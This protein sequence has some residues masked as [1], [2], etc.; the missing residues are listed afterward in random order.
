MQLS[1]VGIMY[2][3]LMYASSPPC[4]SNSSRV[5]WISSPMFCFFFCP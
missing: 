5:S 2:L 3:M 4:F 1:Y